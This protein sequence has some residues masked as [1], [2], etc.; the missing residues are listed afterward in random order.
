M[1]SFRYKNWL[2]EWDK[3]GQAYILY[4][5]AELEQPR[6]FRYPETECETVQMCKEFIDSYS[7]EQKTTK[8]FKPQFGHNGNPYKG[9]LARGAI[10]MI[11]GSITIR[12]LPHSEK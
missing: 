9:K 10:M 12:P 1:K 6:G 8:Y 4:T 11:N 7:D 2:C 5:P 3:S